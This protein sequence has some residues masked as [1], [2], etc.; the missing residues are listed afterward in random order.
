M[1]V[2]SSDEQ[3]I[4]HV[5]KLFPESQTTTTM[6]EL[7]HVENECTTGKRSRRLA[8]VSQVMYLRI[9][10]WTQPRVLSQTLNDRTPALPDLPHILLQ[11]S[12]AVH[13]QYSRQAVQILDQDLSL[14]PRRSIFRCQGCVEDKY[15]RLPNTSGC[16]DLRTDRFDIT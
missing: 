12:A 11:S 6:S 14:H 16:A 15:G 10:I 4:P 9:F 13:V 1:S 7:F 2:C 3:V 8:V 5:C